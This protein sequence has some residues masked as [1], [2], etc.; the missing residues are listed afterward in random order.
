MIGAWFA[1]PFVDFFVNAWNWIY[2]KAF[3]V[4]AWIINKFR[5]I[6]DFVTSLPG[7][8][9]SAARGMWDG[10]VWAFKGAINWLIG[11]WNRLDFGINIHVPDWIPGIGGMGFSVPDLLPDLPYLAQGGIVPATPGGRLAVLGEG[12]QDEAVIPLSQLKSQTEVVVRYDTTG[13]EQELL[14]LLRKWI[15]IYGPADAPPVF[16]R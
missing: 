14:R 16:G 1:G 5:S 3:E 7:K 10:I 13:A 2:A 9:A 11:L 8:I 4:T 6:V 12:G 15:R